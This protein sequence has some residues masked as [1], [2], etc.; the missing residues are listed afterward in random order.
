MKGHSGQ[1]NLNKAYNKAVT[2]KSGLDMLLCWP[3]GAPP[4]RQ[5]AHLAEALAVSPRPSLQ[6]RE[7][8]WPMERRFCGL[9][10]TTG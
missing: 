6:T 5:Q 3:R 4:R 1:I 9:T 8:N 10:A 2:G 7:E